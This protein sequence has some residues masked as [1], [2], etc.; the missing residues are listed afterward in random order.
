MNIPFI[1]IPD[2]REISPGEERGLHMIGKISNS[3]GM[4]L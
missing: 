2:E 1:F 3:R 4:F